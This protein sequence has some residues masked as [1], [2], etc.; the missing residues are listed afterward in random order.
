MLAGVASFWLSVHYVVDETNTK[1]PS[2]V[3]PVAPEAEKACPCR[4]RL[5]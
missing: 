1:N 3:A 2:G 4:V 5:S